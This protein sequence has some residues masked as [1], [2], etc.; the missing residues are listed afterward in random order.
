MYGL[1]AI[2]A[3]SAIVMLISDTSRALIL[4]LSVLLFA[5]FAFVNR[6]AG[7]HEEGK[8]G[9]PEGEQKELNEKKDTK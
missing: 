4:I 3:I 9:S 7:K 5:L 6:P 1:S 8:D 2:L